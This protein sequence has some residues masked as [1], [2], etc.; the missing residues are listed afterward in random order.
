MGWSFTAYAFRWNTLWNEGSGTVLYLKWVSL[1]QR[2]FL[3]KVYKVLQVH[4]H[5]T[6]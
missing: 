6:M 5:S 4:T 1:G 3:I 2:L